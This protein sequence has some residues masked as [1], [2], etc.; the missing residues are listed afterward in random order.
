MRPSTRRTLLVLA[1]LA[2]GLVALAYSRLRL[3]GT[4]DEP[5][6]RAAAPG[7]VAGAIDPATPT[8]LDSGNVD[9][10]AG[11][12]ADAL[13]HYRSAV[14]ANPGRAAP[15]FGV[16][17]AALRLGNAALAESARVA[18]LARIDTTTPREGRKRATTGGRR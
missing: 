8:A 17:M 4:V 16:R 9:Y 10:R 1:A 12:Y 5:G 7:S 13:A 2:V 3:R 14:A 15:Y 18:I 6:G 11:R